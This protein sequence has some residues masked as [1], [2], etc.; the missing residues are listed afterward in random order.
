MKFSRYGVFR[1]K[2]SFCMEAGI[3]YHRYF[4]SLISSKNPKQP[5]LNVE[6]HLK[7]LQKLMHITDSNRRGLSSLNMQSTCFQGGGSKKDKMRSTL[8]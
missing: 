4:Y 1:T 7:S 5:L 3:I 6:I 2:L 8:L